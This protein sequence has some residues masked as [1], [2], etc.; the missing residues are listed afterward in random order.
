MKSGRI[1]GLAVA[2]SATVLM[3]GCSSD[4][5]GNSTSGPGGEGADEVTL[6]VFAAA[7]LKNGFTAL[8]EQFSEDN[9]TIEVRF[10]F[11]GS[12]ALV[13]QIRQGAPADVIATAD[14]TNMA[15]LDGAVDDPRIFA[16]NVLTIVTQPGNPKNIQG[17]A[18]LTR[19]DVSTVICAAAVPCGVATA[20]VEETSGVD[21]EPVSEE[22]AVTGVLTK[23]QTGQADAGLVYVTDATGAGETVTAVSDPAFTSVVNAY[24]IGVVAASENKQASQ[25]F[26][27]LVL[28]AR[29][30]ALLQSMGFGP[31]K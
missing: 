25:K 16:T 20:K 26:V 23:V 3:A 19:S 12:Q 7:S 11:D 31:A 14:E 21:I 30:A 13:T 4:D 15:K 17:L 18:D 10:N 8:A 6:T 2:L 5:D 22:T 9:P 28:G 29:G 24:P 1:T 27:D